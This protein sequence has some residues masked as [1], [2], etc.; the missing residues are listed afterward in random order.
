MRFSRS[1]AL[2]CRWR[3]GALAPRLSVGG[4]CCAARSQATSS[5]VTRHVRSGLAGSDR[6]RDGR[7]WARTLILGAVLAPNAWGETTFYQARVAPILERHCVSCHGPEKQKAGLRLDSFEALMKGAESGPVVVA[8]EAKRSE[9]LRRITLPVT[10][11]EVMPG[12]GKPLLSREEIANL[13]RW[14]RDGASPTRV[15]ADF[16]GAPPLR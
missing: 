15:V 9:L 6:F 4:S 16:P 5:L 14:V 8:G 3:R 12:D 7:R 1:I 10:D 13:E 2:A 11:E